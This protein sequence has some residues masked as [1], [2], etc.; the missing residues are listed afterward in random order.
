[1]MSHHGND[2]LGL[3]KPSLLTGS[4]EEMLRKMLDSSGFVGATG[5][6]PAGQISVDDEGGIQFA[7]KPENGKLIIDFGKPVSWVGMSPQEA[8]DLAGSLVKMARAI[9]RK[10]GDRS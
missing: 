3:N 10:N 1:M 8:C 7:I 2:P 4:R 5:H 6:F 9:A